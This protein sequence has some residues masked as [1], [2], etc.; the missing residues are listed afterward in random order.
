MSNSFRT[1]AC[2][3]A[4]AVALLA[5]SALGSLQAQAAD[6]PARVR[7]TIASLEGNKMVVHGREGKDVTVELTPDFAVFAVVKADRSEI[8]KGSFI[9]TASLPQSDQSLM[10]LELVVFPES[11]RGFAEGHYSWDLKPSSMMT[12]AT[13]SN[14][15][16]GTDGDKI[17]VSYKGGEK[18]IT[19]PKDV[20]IVALVAASKSDLKP[21]AEV[22]VPAKKDGDTIRS[23]AVL[24]GKDGVKPPM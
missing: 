4:V 20:P 18:T 6:Q 12:N 13:V 16:Q 3:W 21:G 9:G 23:G 7:G 5:A 10:S 17:T 8:K 24:F 15:V 2:R 19:V 14:M 11:L 22:F 1:G